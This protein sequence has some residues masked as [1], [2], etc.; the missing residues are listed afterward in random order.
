MGNSSELAMCT[1]TYIAVPTSG[2]AIATVVMV[3]RNVL[4]VA[5]GLYSL[6]QCTP[7]LSLSDA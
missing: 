4:R 3:F 1:H 5:V 7:N 6:Q 2:T